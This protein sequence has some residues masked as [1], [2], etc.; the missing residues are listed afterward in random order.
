VSVKYKPNGRL[1]PLFG[2]DEAPTT[3]FW[4]RTELKKRLWQW[5][6]QQNLKVPGNPGVVKLTG[7]VY[8]IFLKPKKEKNKNRPDLAPEETITKKDLS[9]RFDRELQ[10]YTAVILPDQPVK[11]KFGPIPRIRISTENRSGGRKHVTH[12]SGLETF[13]IDPKEFANMCRKKFA[14]ATSAQALEGKQRKGLMEVKIAGQM[15]DQTR[16]LLCDKS[17]YHIPAKFIR[18]EEAKQ[19]KKDKEDK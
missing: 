5:V 1:S 18:I 10:Q 12:I 11:Y 3:R 4:T 13:G 2:K 16:D 7:E 14:C 19:P 8:R 9:D 6:D 15:D 17:T